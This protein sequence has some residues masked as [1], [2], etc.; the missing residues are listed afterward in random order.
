MTVQASG[1]SGSPITI[2]FEPNAK[3]SEPACGTCLTISKRSYIVV[4]GGTNGV[5]ENTNNGTTMSH[6]NGSHGIDAAS[7]S[8]CEIRNLTIQNI[9]VHSGSNTEIDQTSERCVYFSGD[10]FLIHNNTMHDA[11]WCLYLDGTAVN[12][13]IYNNNIYNI[14]HAI[15]TTPD[16]QSA[17][18]GPLYIYGNHIHDYANWDNGSN[19][20]HHDGIHCYTVPNNYPQPSGPPIQGAHWNGF[21]IYNNVFDGSIGGNITGH[22]FLEPGVQTD[23]TATPC[24]DATSQ[25]HIF[26]NF[27]RADGQDPNGIIDMGRASNNPL[28]VPVDFYNNTVIGMNANAGRAVVFESVNTVNA[29]NNII[30]GQNKLW[31]G[32]SSANTDNNGY[33]NCPTSVSFNCWPTSG[34]TNNFST[35]QSGCKCDAH[36]VN[37]QSN[38]DGVNSTNGSLQSGSAMIGK[39]LNL[40]SA[41]SAWPSEQQSALAVDAHGTNRGGASWDI[42]AFSFGPSA[43]VN[44]PTGLT[45]V[46][47]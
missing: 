4:D 47:Q 41:V 45:A 10:N 38:F 17:P 21:W 32:V 1:A 18:A 44:P 43:T 35:W 42:G 27:I 11:G 22:I 26:G 15:I 24:M 20:Y 39:G 16:S 13:R 36:S 12:N 46:V 34:G 6:V 37:S 28:T 31:D 14:D 9:Y 19:A 29:A 5:I 3:I 2:L 40:A 23:G 30:G 33:V 8:N 7:C 25:I